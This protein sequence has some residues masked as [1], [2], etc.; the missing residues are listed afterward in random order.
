MTTNDRRVLVHPDKKAMTGSVAARFLTKLVDILD[1]EETANVVLTG[2]TVGP[3]ILA[4]VNESAARDS[5]DWTRV[6]FW[7]GDERWLPHGDP[8]RNDTTVREALLDHI[9]VPAGNIHAMGAS[10][11]GQSLDEAVAAYR[12]ELAEHADG[13][14]GLPRF[15]ITFLGVGPDGHVASLFPDSEGIRTMDAAVIAVRN[16]PKPP[17]ERISLTLPV[18]NSSLRIWM[19]LAG[20]DKAFA[21]GLALAGADRTEVPVAGIKGRKRTVFFIDREAAADVP[22][23]LRLSSY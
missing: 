16:S 6:H 10:D 5:V 23:N 9:D 1:E 12:T 20:P 21:L 14:A 22:E 18:L 15:D 19:V 3:S 8:E 13:D 11:A 2:G 17:A 4:A 7:F